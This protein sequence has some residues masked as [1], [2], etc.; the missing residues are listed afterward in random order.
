MKSIYDVAWLRVSRLVIDGSRIRFFILYMDFKFVIC[1]LDLLS[2]S[3]VIDN[4]I[5]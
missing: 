4:H 1:S 5:T 3:Y 2:W